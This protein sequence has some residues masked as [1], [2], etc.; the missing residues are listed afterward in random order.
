MILL[1]EKGNSLVLIDVCV[2]EIQ[3]LD[4]PRLL[5]FIITVFKD[6]RLLLI[7]SQITVF[8]EAGN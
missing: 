7:R 8:W 5:R 4:N 3:S 6:M 2:A 1:G